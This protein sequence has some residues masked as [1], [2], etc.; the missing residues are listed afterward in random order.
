[1]CED[2]KIK[3]NL[4]AVAAVQSLYEDDKIEPNLETAVAAVQWAVIVGMEHDET[5]QTILT[6]SEVIEDVDGVT[7][8]VDGKKF[9]V[10]VTEI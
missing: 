3:T 5:G 4:E 6:D 2:D 10:T 9:K 8:V 7:I 1:M